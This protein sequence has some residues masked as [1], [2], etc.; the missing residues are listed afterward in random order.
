M[1]NHRQ[2]TKCKNSTKITA[3]YERLSR[4]DDLDGTSNS[5]V[6]QRQILEDYAVKNVFT[7]IRH[8]QDDGY[9]GTNWDRPGWNALIAE[10]EAGNVGVVIVK[11]MSRIGRDYLQVGFYTEVM[12]RQKGVRFIAISNNID[13]TN[14]ESGEFAPF[15]NIMSEWYARDTSR[16][17][18]TSFHAKG[19]G[20]KRLTANAIYGYRK[21]PNDKNVWLIDEEAAEVVR[22]IFQMSLNGM[23]PNQ[24]ARKLTEEKVERPSYYAV[25][26]GLKLAS[27]DLSNPYTCHDSTVGAILSK[28][29]YCGHTVNFRTYKDSYK[30]KSH[31]DNPKEN[32]KIFENTHE[33]I[34]DQETFDTVQR[35]RGT[36]RR[37]DTLGKANPLTGLMFCADCGVKMY[38]SRNPKFDIY[39][40]SAYTI[41]TAHY[42]KVCSAHYIR[43]VVVRELVL[44]SIQ[45]I[46]GYVRENE[47]EFIEQIRKE[48]AVQQDETAKS[49]KKLIAKNERRIAELDNLF[50]KV[51]EDNAIGK[52]SDERF[53]QLSSAYETEQAEL[54]TQNSKLQIELDTFNEDS[55]K[56]DKFIEIVRRYTEFGE[57]TT[58]MLN[59]FVD[60]ILVHQSDK[61]SGERIQKVDIFFNFIGNFAVP[62]EK[63]L[64]A[65]DWEEQE[66]Q[67]QKREKQREYNR[68]W[69]AKK[70]AEAEREKQAKVKKSA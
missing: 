45:R 48:S 39:Q 5:I 43:T 49:H 27:H 69:Y 18:K 11:D 52:L 19:N 12:F 68:R 50:R 15:L 30:D 23:G 54:K 8:F 63:P 9:S 47:D 60:K 1:S 29:E 21:G 2:T 37:N 46:S 14:A 33:A 64:T 40:C 51:Y 58:P 25:R 7:N 44:S 6:N 53:E 13:S 22:R 4:D 57:L 42:K 26:K 24:I 66:K 35:L 20:G 59:E 62:I 55:Q 32:W 28:P 34:I 65:E 70:K 56:A 41:G 61:S 3:L 16:K 17:I 10:V 67:R 36:P 31:K 38:N